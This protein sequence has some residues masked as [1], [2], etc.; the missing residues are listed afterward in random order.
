MTKEDF[1]K[2]QYQALREEI[3][4]TQ[5]RSFQTL[6]FGALSIP[7]AGYLAEVHNVPALSLTVPLL[8]I[9]IALLYLADNHGIMRCG[10]YIK[11]HIE[12]ELSNE[13]TLGWETWLEKGQEFG[14]RSTEHYT[15]LCFYLL[16]LLYFIAAIFMAWV[17]MQPQSSPFVFSLPFSVTLTVLYAVFGVVV[18]WHIVRSIRLVPRSYLN[19]DSALAKAEE[20]NG[21]ENRPSSMEVQAPHNPSLKRTPD[22]AA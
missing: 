5:R 14:T 6:G 21:V 19:F 16:F 9:G 10:E 4:A 2:M 15:T 7:A 18:A 20:Q 3:L 22:G 17:Y 12:K 8:I 11:E 1:L 13:G